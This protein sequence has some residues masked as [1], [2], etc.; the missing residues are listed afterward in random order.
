[1]FLKHLLLLECRKTILKCA[2]FNV[3][4]ISHRKPYINDFV[5]VLTQTAA[6]ITSLDRLINEKV[7]VE[8]IAKEFVSTSDG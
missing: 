3:N 2:L 5:N 1:M 8:L 7:D 6:V 4:K